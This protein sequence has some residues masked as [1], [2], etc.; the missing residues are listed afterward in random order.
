MR[1]GKTEEDIDSIQ[2]ECK[3]SYL[4]QVQIYEYLGTAIG[5]TTKWKKKQGRNIK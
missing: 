2:T 3:G 1:I 4:Q 5:P